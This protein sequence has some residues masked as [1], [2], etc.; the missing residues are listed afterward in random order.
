MALPRKLK[1][2]SVFH[3][4]DQFLGEATEL[5]LPKLAVKTEAYRGGGMVAEVD[6][7][8][9]LEKLELEHSYGGLMYEIFKDFG[10]TQMDGT[11]LR[12]M[13]S[14][15]REDTGEVDAVEITVRGRH[16]EIDPGSAKAGDDTEFK[17]KT[18]I[19]YY[20]LTVNG[21]TLFEVDTLNQIYTVNGVDRLAAHRAAI[22]R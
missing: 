13:G 5:T 12:F 10:I 8:L 22:G 14:Y 2:F 4:G 11:L 21:S 18:N 6:I 3:N 16:V 1:F 15:Q 19:A 17:V 7:D 9:G 20:K